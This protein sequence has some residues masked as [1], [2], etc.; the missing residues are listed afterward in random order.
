[1][2][3]AAHWFSQPARRRLAG[4]ALLVL[5]LVY[6]GAEGVRGVV[7][8]FVVRPR[9]G[10]V[11]VLFHTDFIEL[12]RYLDQHREISDIAVGAQI[13][14]RWNQVAFGIALERADVRARWYD[15]CAAQLALP[16]GSYAALPHY[17]FPPG[18]LDDAVYDDPLVRT[19]D[20]LVALTP[21]EAPMDSGGGEV[22]FAPGLTLVGSRQENVGEAARIWTT[23]RVD[24]PLELP[25]RLLYAKPP[26]PGEPDKPRLWVFLHVLP[27]G[28]DRPV[29]AE[30]G[31]G[32]DPYTLR[33]GDLLSVPL[34]VPLAELAAG[35]YW[36]GV[37]LFDVWTGARWPALDGRDVV[38]IGEFE[39]L[40]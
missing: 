5:A 32:A 10:Y 34:D 36:L 22:P 21:A 27:P 7:D 25:P 14:E 23:W 26:A 33:P 4:K 12:A 16:D 35:Q 38:I 28:G 37:G 29:L 13:E 19:G 31:L 11:R 3:K 8:Y 6:L 2:V 30:S 20:F 18:T 24:A 39:V 40:G 9:D 1:V 17:L 15:P